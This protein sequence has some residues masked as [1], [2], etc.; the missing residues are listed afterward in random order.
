MLLTG[1][2]IHDLIKLEA[3]SQRLI[4]ITGASF[5]D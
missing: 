4:R 3:I 5:T 2:L 1:Y